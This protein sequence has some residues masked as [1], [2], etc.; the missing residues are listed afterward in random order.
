MSVRAM[1]TRWFMPPLS[2]CGYLLRVL[3]RIEADLGDPLAGALAAF[4]FRH[5]LAFETEGD[6]VEHGAVREIRV[7]LEH[8]AAVRA[9]F[10]DR[11]AV[12]QHACRR[13][14]ETAG[15]VRR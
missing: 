5:L 11:L 8:E 9:G 2:W 4:L 15:P 3:F 1:A 12:H 14:R 13:S 6:V 10:R 7:I